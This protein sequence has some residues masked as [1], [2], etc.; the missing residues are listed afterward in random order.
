MRFVL[1]GVLIV[2]C[3]SLSR[4]ATEVELVDCNFTPEVKKELQLT[5]EQQPKVEKVLAEIG[6]MAKKTMAARAKRD[7]LRSS[8]A[9]ADQV[10]AA[11]N[12]LIEL[13]H[14][15]GER[16]H[17]MLKPILTDAQFEKIAEMEAVHGHKISG[18]GGGGHGPGH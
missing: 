1:S 13:E 14:Q 17:E 15:C 10:E 7:G 6:P 12:E 11:Q 3:A 4:A 16:Y 2:L 18:Q 9:P 5:A 8:N